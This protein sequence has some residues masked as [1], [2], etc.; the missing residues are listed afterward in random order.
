MANRYARDFRLK[1]ARGN[2][3]KLLWPRRT[4]NRNDSCAKEGRLVSAFP[5]AILQ[6][7]QCGGAALGKQDAQL[8]A[9][10]KRV[11]DGGDHVSRNV[12]HF[13]VGKA[14][15]QVRE[16]LELVVCHK[17]VHRA[18]QDKHREGGRG[19]EGEKTNRDFSE[20]SFE[21]STGSAPSA[22]LLMSSSVSMTAFRT[23]FGSSAMLLLLMKLRCRRKKDIKAPARYNKG[24]NS[25]RMLVNKE[26]FGR[27]LRLLLL[28]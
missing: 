17:S 21:T 15:E 12:E 1:T 23:E 5:V 25:E 14:S 24:A 20:T 8:G 19:K 9:R 3:E 13:Q 16:R 26:Q 22:L 2:V 11:G 10:R 4:R 28:R 27:S 18:E 7:G 6:K